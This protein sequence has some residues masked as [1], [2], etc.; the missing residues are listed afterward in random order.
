MKQN[1][2]T[3][4]ALITILL[5]ILP[6]QSLA[7]ISLIPA[8]QGQR[9]FSFEV[10]AGEQEQA[11]LLLNNLGDEDVS[12]HLY[13]A[14]GTQSNQ[15]TFAL[16]TLDTE[17]KNIGKARAAARLIYD[18]SKK[19]DSFESIDRVNQARKKSQEDICCSIM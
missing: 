12:I 4:F 11:K 19:R 9:Q 7:G 8:N 10:K 5:L 16:T 6:E 13:G 14:D 17:Q 15:G 1:L 2:I 3:K 18:P